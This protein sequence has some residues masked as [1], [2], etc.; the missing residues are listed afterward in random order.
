MND[1]KKAAVAA[2]KQAEA[3][4][5]EKTAGEKA[6][7]E[8]E[9]KRKEK[10]VKAGLAGAIARN[11]RE[12]EKLAQHDDQAIEAAAAELAQSEKAEEEQAGALEE[13]ARIDREHA[14]VVASDRVRARHYDTVQR[15]QE[16][17]DGR[18]D[19]QVLTDGGVQLNR[20][21]GATIYIRM[22]GTE[23]ERV[24]DAARRFANS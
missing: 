11:Q 21:D 3:G 17:C 19:V 10:N 20:K 16:I 24:I 8:R 1:L 4:E 7:L 15:V 9:R 13:K 23:P 14:A 2:M 22:D 18:A 12:A 6:R 5:V